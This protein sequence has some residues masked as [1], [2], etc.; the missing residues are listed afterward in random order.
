[1]WQTDKVTYQFNLRGK[2]Q[3]C[4]IEVGERVTPS[5]FFQVCV[6]VKKTFFLNICIYRYKFFPE[7]IYAQNSC[8]LNIIFLL[9]ICMGVIFFN[10]LFMLHYM[11]FVCQYFKMLAT[12][13]PPFKMVMITNGKSNMGRHFDLAPFKAE[14]DLHQSFFGLGQTFFQRRLF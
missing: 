1:M 6:G 2:A 5:N 8:K 14:P 9:I 4:D 10:K 11:H 12:S 13:P 7:V 3:S